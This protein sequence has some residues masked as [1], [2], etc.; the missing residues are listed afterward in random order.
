MPLRRRAL[1][2]LVAVL[3]AGT[4]VALATRHGH[5]DGDRGAGTTAAPARVATTGTPPPPGSTARVL[6][7]LGAG[8]AGSAPVT[9]GAWHY[10]GDPGD[11]GAARHWADGH[12]G[13]RVVTVPY[14]PNARHVTGPGA[15]RAYA[16]SVGWYARTID[17][18]VTARYSLGFASAHFAATVY[19]DGLRVR[20]HVGAYE[21]FTAGA[22]LT[23]GVH[24]VAVRVDWRD[25]L[26]QVAAGYAR[27]WFNYGGL[28]GPVTLTRLGESELGALRVLTRLRGR[29]AV[30]RVSARVRNRLA[31]PRR[32]AVTGVLTRDGVRLPVRFRAVRVPPDDSRPVHAT[33]IVRGAAL[34]S[35]AHPRRYA[36]T[37]G[38]RRQA[39][40]RTYV[41]L[42]ELRWWGAKLR[43]NGRTLRLQ[44]VGLPADI[45]GHGDA[46]TAADEA[47]TVRELV[48][49]GANATRS[50][51]PLSASMLDRLD[52]AGILVWQ[53]LGPWETPSGFHAR[54]V[55]A[56]TDR[57]LRT[58]ELEQAHP[59]VVAWTLTNEVA[60]NGRPRQVGYVVRTARTL[61]ARDP[62][63]PVA[64]D[65]WGRHLTR[66]GGPMFDAVDALGVTDYTGW[67]E[68]TDLGRRAQ[69]HEVRARL[70]GLR[71]LFPGKPIV[72]TELGAAGTRRVPAQQFGGVGFQA[73]L[74]ARRVAM[75][76]GLPGISGELLWLLRD[77]AL[78]PDFR[79]GS[80][81]DAHPGLVLTPGLNEKGLYDYA[82]RPK[83]A[84]A[85]VRAAFR[86]ARP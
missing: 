6:L 8:P 11:R 15:E 52:A 77:H 63:R 81:L 9:L 56:A 28:N 38:V 51:L 14:S 4:G 7:T 33:V 83:P 62:G 32:L 55:G 37:L 31:G 22:S 66:T 53:E 16:G 17:V 82:G 59:S 67:Y 41:G 35:A 26:A 69:A 3:L 18:P 36:L 86:G 27:G 2:L 40:L 29:D 24:T 65:L 58:A 80:V 79:G 61:H 42:R 45:E 75:L 44:G 76:R 46:M 54:S 72:V 50:Q 70:A 43:L 5:G 64:I 20:R 34:W 21:P 78:R 10:R 13:G 1:G 49:T 19:V 30:V 39:T 25:P 85:A 68:G 71:A 47:R 48:A 73:D 74:L 60:G 23:A 84:L 12:F 57:A